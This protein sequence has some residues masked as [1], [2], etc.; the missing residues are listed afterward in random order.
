M[1]SYVEVGKTGQ[2]P[3]GSLQKVTVG[4]HEILLARVGKSYYAVGNRCTHMNGDLSLGKLEGR[5]VTCPRH[6]SQF[7]LRDGSVVR[8]MKGSGIMAA[9]GKALKSPRPL[10]RY[11]VRVDGDTVL[12]EI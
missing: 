12:V 1:G 5:I 6:G 7:D 3:D 4:A 8:W 10:P 11:K 2:F 9:L